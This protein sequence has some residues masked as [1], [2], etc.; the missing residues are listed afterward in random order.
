MGLLSAFL[1][2][3]FSA[4]SLACD[5]CFG[6]SNPT[7]HQRLSRR[8][9]PESLNATTPPKKPLEWGQLNFLHTTDTHGWLEGHLKEK[10]Y[11]ADWGDYVSFTRHMKQKAENLG[12]DL[13]LVDTGKTL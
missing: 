3:S 9:Q 4:T 11:G 5:S 1:L 10:N 2:L 8:A 13:L 7:I 12:V 6:P